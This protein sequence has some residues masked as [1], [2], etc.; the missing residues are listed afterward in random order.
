MRA[1]GG[2][3][4]VVGAWESHTSGIGSRLL[5]RMGYTPVRPHAH[6]P[7]HTHHRTRPRPPHT[8][9]T[10]AHAPPHTAHTADGE[11]GTRAKDWGEAARG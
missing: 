5:A 3:D 11:R 9:T 4:Y 8:T 7:P 10:T 1:T 2:H 6:A